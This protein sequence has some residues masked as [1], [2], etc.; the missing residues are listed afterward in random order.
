[1]GREMGDGAD[2]VR[3]GS[4]RSGRVGRSRW[5]MEC[6]GAVSGG[7]P[8]GGIA[9]RREGARATNPNVGREH[10]GRRMWHEGVGGKGDGRR[11]GRTPVRG[12]A[13]GRYAK[14]SAEEASDGSGESGMRTDSGRALGPRA[15]VEGDG[16]LEQAL[17]SV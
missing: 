14:S 17:N 16:A 11:G 8:S 9:G 3:G 1:M 4:Y 6:R 5:P 12:R 10:E 7:G 13:G 15:V 2:V